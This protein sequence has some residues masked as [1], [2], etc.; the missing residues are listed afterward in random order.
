MKEAEE[1]LNALGEMKKDPDL[2]N[3]IATPHNPSSSAANIAYEVVA[4]ELAALK[5]DLKK[6]EEHLRKA[7][8]YED[9][10]TYTEPA[11]WYIPTRQNLGTLLLKARKYE[12]AEKIFKEDLVTLRQN[13]WSL[14]GLY[15]SLELQGKVKE[16]AAVKKEFDIAWKYADFK[17]AGAVL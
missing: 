6:A 8:V 15:Q 14:M 17:I 9:N 10:L 4:G 11:A 13:G 2:E 3:L 5:G 1:E 16:A 7:V 12:D